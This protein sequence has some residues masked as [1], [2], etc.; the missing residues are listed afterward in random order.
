MKKKLLTFLLALILVFSVTAMGACSKNNGGNA[1]DSGNPADNGAGKS[2]KVGFVVKSLADQYWILVKAGA[3]VAAEENGVDLT[4]I[5]PNSES[6]VAKQVENIETLIANGV[7]ILCVAPSNDETVLP[8]LQSAVDAG[9]KVIAVD[10]DSSLPD[11]ISFIGTGNEN[12]AR[13]G[14]LWA[15]EQIGEGGTAIILRG[16][17][18]DKTHD[19]RSAGL[20]A[21]LKEKGVEIL[22]VEPADSTEELGN[23]KALNLVNKFESEGKKVD[24]II[25]TADSMA[26]GAYEGVKDKGIKVYGFDGTIPVCELV[27]SGDMLGTTAQSPYEMGVL[28]IETAIKVMNGE[29][30][31]KVIDSGQK[32]IS[33]DNVSEFLKDLQAKVNRAG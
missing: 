20:E 7:D 4:F 32:V 26:K 3:E 16:R 22:A 5:A 1:N 33:I 6:D 25:T 24:L 13:E 9:I 21:G 29:T 27:G 10:T 28:G 11:K 14:A 30:V 2:V 31:E 19:D 23:N 17:L 12:A 18:G 15:G 8:A